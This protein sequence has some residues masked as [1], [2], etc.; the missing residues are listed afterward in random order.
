MASLPDNFLVTPQEMIIRG[1][2]YIKMRINDY[3]LELYHDAVHNDSHQFNG[4]FS[5]NVDMF[6]EKLSIARDLSAKERMI[7]LKVL[8][9]IPQFLT[10][11][12]FL[13]YKT[14]EK[15]Y[16]DTG[17]IAKTL[18]SEMSNITRIII[19]LSLP[20]NLI[21]DFPHILYHYRQ[22]E[23]SINYYLEILEIERLGIYETY[24]NYMKDM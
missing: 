11:D 13:T 1:T 24:K 8:P 3:L 23:D 18:N 2:Y 4:A 17:Y 16:D 5:K 9:N 12:K 22:A 10:G 7:K 14:T 15:I 6:T 20:I 21:I 19:Y